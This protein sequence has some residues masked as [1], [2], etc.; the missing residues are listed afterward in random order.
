MGRTSLALLHR[1]I[2]TT[3]K[4]TADK[5]FLDFYCDQDKSAFTAHRFTVLKI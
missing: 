4:P 1:R 5:A 2:K 3:A